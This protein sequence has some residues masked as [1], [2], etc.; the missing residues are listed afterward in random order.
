M[1]ALI[2]I[3]SINIQIIKKE[4]FQKMDQN[5]YHNMNQASII[6]IYQFKIKQMVDR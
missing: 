5:Q 4:I 1:Q 6:K 2:E 3:P